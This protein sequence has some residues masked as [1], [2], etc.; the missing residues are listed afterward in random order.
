MRNH[1]LLA[2][3]IATGLVLGTYAGLVLLATRVLAFSSPIGVAA[4]KISASVEFGA[5]IVSSLF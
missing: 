3:A 1:R 2:L 5:T 4:R